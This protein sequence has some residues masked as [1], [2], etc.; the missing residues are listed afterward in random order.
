MADVVVVGKG[1]AARSAAEVL[2]RAGFSLHHSLDLESSGRSPVILGDLTGGLGIA[3]EAIESGRH[4]LITNPVNLPIE[5]LQ[6]LLDS[7]RR[8]QALFVWSERRHHPGYKF[9]SGLI[10]AD[11][12]WVPRFLRMDYLSSEQATSN[13][14]RWRVVESMVLAQS[15]AAA[16]PLNVSAH[17]V[18]NPLR[19]A[20]DQLQINVEL[21][22]YE[23][24]L[25]VGLGEAIERR[26]TLLAAGDRKAFVDEMNQSVPVRLVDAEPGRLESSPARWVSCPA[27]APDELARQQCLGFLEATLD[28]GL[29]QREASRWVRALS[30]LKAMERSLLEN[31]RS[32]EVARQAEEPRFRLLQGR[33]AAASGAPIPA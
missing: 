16:A 14:L 11:G 32:I 22:D 4:L 12:T 5:R 1:F 29:A 26:E 17:A 23:A 28:S 30:V 8:A 10:E 6:M 3:R 19:T 31:G 13:L 27:P 2:S 9:I 18:A 15:V 21:D 25:Q 7:R 24:F 33:G 20:T